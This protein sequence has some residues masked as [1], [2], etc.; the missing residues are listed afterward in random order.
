M[1]SS[2]RR[3][4]GD[5]PFNIGPIFEAFTVIQCL[6]PLVGFFALLAACK[7]NP[8]FLYGS[9]SVLLAIFTCSSIFGLVS[10]RVAPKDILESI[11]KTFRKSSNDSKIM[12][13]MNDIQTQVINHDF[14][15]LIVTR[16]QTKC[17]V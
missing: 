15:V 7:K 17:L 1:Q 8:L 14:D 13:W 10:Y 12:D 16:Y 11:Y 3:D 4:I 9:G 5:W 2:E 6:F